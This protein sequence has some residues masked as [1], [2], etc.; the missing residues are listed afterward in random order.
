MGKER[1]IYKIV[2]PEGKERAL[3]L[4]YDD[5][6]LQ[7]RRL[8]SLLRE[9][10]VKATFNLNS[11]RLA[12]MERSLV[13]GPELDVSTV[14]SEEIPTLYE[15][16]EV[17]THGRTHSGLKNL[18]ALACTEVLEDRLALEKIVPYLVQGHAYPYGSFDESVKTALRAAGI[19]YARTI[20]PTHAFDLPVDFLEWNPTCHHADP[21]LMELIRDFCEAPRF[22]H[23]PL[24]FYLWGHS[25][26]FDQF[27]NW[28]VIETFLSYVSGFKDKI[29][30]ATNIEIVDYL[31]A[32]K[33]LEMSADG[34]RIY[35]SAAIPIWF[36]VGSL[37]QNRKLHRIN[38]GEL[39]AVY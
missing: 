25:Y 27:D 39:V 33:T 22:I 5:G 30:F 38:P 35:N 24:L 14:S 32:C 37:G 36:E 20:T 17:A 10:G 23:S 16:F 7:D 28:P 1:L 3:T 34:Q 29:W 8:V 18:G 26:E 6:V 19:K 11:G 12:R 4:S 9:Y 15:G 31:E 2:Y 21:E 13:F